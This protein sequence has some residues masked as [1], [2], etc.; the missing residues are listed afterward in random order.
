ML[1]TNAWNTYN[2]TQ[3]KAVEKLAVDYKNFL[4]K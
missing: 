1:R 4:D 3:L 2:K